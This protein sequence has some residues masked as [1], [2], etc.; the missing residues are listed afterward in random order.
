[1]SL[2]SIDL[3]KID[4]NSIKSSFCTKN[5]VHTWKQM[6]NNRIDPGILERGKSLRSSQLKKERIEFKN[7]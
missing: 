6:S 7:T 5:L 4:T 2:E 3:N 1:M